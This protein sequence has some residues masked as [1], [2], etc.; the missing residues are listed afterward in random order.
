MYRAMRSYPYPLDPTSK[1]YQSLW[2]DAL[3]IA[4]HHLTARESQI[5]KPRQINYSRLNERNR[6]SVDEAIRES[7]SEND[8]APLLGTDANHVYVKLRFRHEYLG[9]GQKFYVG[10]RDFAY[11]PEDLAMTIPIVM[12]RPAD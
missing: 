3:D 8:S 2:N 1:R 12:D 6:Q 5:R 9:V 4:H 7:T 11:A 10:L